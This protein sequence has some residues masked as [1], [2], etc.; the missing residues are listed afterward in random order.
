MNVKAKMRLYLGDGTPVVVVDRFHKKQTRCYW[1]EGYT[2]ESARKLAARFHQ[3]EAFGWPLNGNYSTNYVFAPRAL[4]LCLESEL[5][6]GYLDPE[7][8]EYGEV[9]P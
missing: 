9:S 7:T 2:V 1:V 3:P 5:D 6:P 8:N 4:S